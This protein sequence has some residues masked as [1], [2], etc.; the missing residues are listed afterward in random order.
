M[1]IYFVKK[2][3]IKHLDYKIKVQSLNP[4]KSVNIIRLKD[5][6]FTGLGRRIR[7]RKVEID[8]DPACTGNKKDNSSIITRNKNDFFSL[9]N[10]HKS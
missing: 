4:S 5:F 9:N 1:H 2:H 7:L 8:Y 3:P 10:K 6:A